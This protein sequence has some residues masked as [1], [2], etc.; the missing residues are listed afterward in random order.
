[1]SV[2][3]MLSKTKDEDNT[4]VSSTGFPR[5]LLRSN[6]KFPLYSLDHGPLLSSTTDRNFEQ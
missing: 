2:F 4:G 5:D 6:P 3:L 1:M